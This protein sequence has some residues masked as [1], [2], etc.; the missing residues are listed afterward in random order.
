MQLSSPYSIFKKN[1][2]R[3]GW[4]NWGSSKLCWN[5][6]LKAG[7]QVLLLTYRR[8]HSLIVQTWCGGLYSSLLAPWIVPWSTLET[9]PTLEARDMP[10]VYQKASIN[11][12]AAVGSQQHS[13]VLILLLPPEPA[14]VGI[15]VGWVYLSTATLWTM[16]GFGA[17][18]LF[19]YL[20][21]LGE[22]IWN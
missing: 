13:G 20:K 11:V 15:R 22:V 5:Y 7:C 16:P 4:W 1:L 19:I 6:V 12:H 3:K 18:L 17:S 9:N 2:H 8:W 21:L 10:C 14:A